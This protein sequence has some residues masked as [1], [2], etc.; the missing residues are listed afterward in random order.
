MRP[1]ASCL[2]RQFFLFGIDV[3]EHTNL[4]LPVFLS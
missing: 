4:Q 1:S 3:K 2:A